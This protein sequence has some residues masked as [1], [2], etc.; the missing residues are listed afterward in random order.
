M[1]TI[2]ISYVNVKVA[3]SRDFFLNCA[4]QTTLGLIVCLKHLYSTYSTVHM[5]GFLSFEFDNFNLLRVKQHTVTVTVQ[6]D[7]SILTD[8]VV[9]FEI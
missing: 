6:S 5:A 3:V 1:K 9:A 8:V 2:G 7:Q 4:N